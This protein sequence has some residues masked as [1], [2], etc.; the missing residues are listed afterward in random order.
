MLSLISAYRELPEELQVTSALR[1]S[2]IS[3]YRQGL[4]TFSLCTDQSGNLESIHFLSTY[5]ASGGV[6]VVGWGWGGRFSEMFVLIVLLVLVLFCAQE[7]SHSLFL[8]FEILLGG[9]RL[10]CA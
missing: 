3:Q 8:L 4:E 10:P 1:G 9:C 7:S 6:C 2:G 5:R